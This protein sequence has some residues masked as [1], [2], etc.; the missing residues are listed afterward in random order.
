M[1]IKRSLKNLY[2]RMLKAD[3]DDCIAR[4]GDPTVIAA[5]QDLSERVRFSDP[6]SHPA[7]GGI[8][9]ELSTT[10]ATIAAALSESDTARATALITKACTLLESRNQRCIMLK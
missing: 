2:I 1:D 8:E 6:M 7:L 3:V 4:T 9:I 10:V 5:L